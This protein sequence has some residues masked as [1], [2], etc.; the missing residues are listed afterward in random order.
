MADRVSSMQRRRLLGAA[1]ACSFLPSTV[2]AQSAPLT[3]ACGRQTARQTAGPFFKPDSP[4]RKSFVE[5][6]GNTGL[7]AVSGRVLSADCK[8]VANALLDFWH[9]DELGEYDDK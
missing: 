7:L 5:K 1:A 2:L 3:P 8:P 4:E 6:H 9:A